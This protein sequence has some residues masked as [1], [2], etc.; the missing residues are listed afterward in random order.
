MWS[1]SERDCDTVQKER[2]NA[3]SMRWHQLFVVA[4]L[5]TT[6]ITAD[7]SSTKG[8][9]SCSN[10]NLGSLPENWS[11][12]DQECIRVDLGI[13]DPGTTLFFEISSNQ[14]IDILLFPSN[15]VSVYQ[16]E[17]SYRIDSVWV[18]ESVFESFSGSGEWHWEVPGDRDSTR[19]YLVV[20]NIA[21]SQDFGEGSQGGQTAEI[22]LDSG[23]IEAQPFTL[24][25]S[26]HRVSPG[27]FSVVHGPFPLDEG[28]FLEIQAR[29]MEG[30]PDIFVMTETAFSYYSP[31]S[32]WSS[33]LRIVSADMLLVGNER[34][35]QWE[36]SDTN[37][38]DLYILVDNR[39][40]PGGGGAGNSV[41]AVTV[42]VTLTPILDP[43]ISSSADLDS[44]DVGSSIT[45]SALE[46]PNK[47]HQILNSGYSWDIDGDGITDANGATIDHVW[48]N[49]GNY[50]VILWAT[51]VDFRTVNNSRVIT[52]I[53][54]SDPVVS[55]GVSGEIT[56][57]FGE[58]LVISA[59]FTDNW[60]VES[61][62]WLLDGNVVW[63]NYTL[64]EPSST[65]FLDVTDSYSPG[66]HVV[67]LV[68]VDKSGRSTKADAHVNFIDVTAPEIAQYESQLEVNSGE[69]II[70]QIYAQDNESD[71]IDYTWTIEQGTEKEAQFSGPQVIYEFSEPGPKNVVCKIENDA[72]LAS[73][74]EILVIVESPEKAGGNSLF[75]I[76]ITSIVL[77]S[78]LGLVGVYA[79]NVFVI[80]RMDE[81]AK[82]E[83]EEEGENPPAETARSQMQM[84]GGGTSASPFEAPVEMT[85]P[86]NQD[87]D[88]V[89]LLGVVGT[90]QE[91]SEN[92][93]ESSLL[94]GLQDSRSNRDSD[95]TEGTKVRKECQQCSRPFEISLPRG[96]ETAYTNCPYCGSEELVSLRDVP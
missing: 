52:V 29:T 46:T 13:H 40:G 61:L 85:S 91:T 71:R 67:S 55:I 54:N 4:L 17:Q 66:P 74:A 41:A 50:T 11:L 6:T 72:G 43:T 70:L 36:A 64:T 31:S 65:L 89:D 18:N 86:P 75:V 39:P 88:L 44:V 90:V 9:I 78:V 1:N 35:L 21:H 48:E 27:E 28:T 33:S 15:T 51:S 73:Y 45:L 10:S 57:G 2:V 96:V 58:K 56:K 26:I 94:S 8:V 24:S 37:G 82:P 22:S 69:P 47:S 3:G 19:W 14:E 76:A 16:N 7:A 83:D 32:N 68:V 77:I 38:E 49:P 53:D 92:T 42:T 63:S 20:D 79:F 80:R 25:D 60:G 93:A 34:H 81:L 23:V 62:D 30:S 84:W 5:L 59:T 95:V 87:S 12:G